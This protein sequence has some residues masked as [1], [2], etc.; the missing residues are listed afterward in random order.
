MIADGRVRV[1]GKIGIDQVAVMKEAEGEDEGGKKG[2]G[3]ETR[4]AGVGTKWWS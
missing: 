3:K 4:R 1:E 2:S